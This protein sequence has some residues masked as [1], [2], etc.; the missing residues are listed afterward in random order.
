MSDLKA[1]VIGIISAITGGGI[2]GLVIDIFTAVLIGAAG[3]LGA[4]AVNRFLNKKFPNET[5]N[6]L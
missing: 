3:A 1:T 2:L 6:K 4:W 5:N